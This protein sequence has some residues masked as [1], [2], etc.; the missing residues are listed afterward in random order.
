MSS[1]GYTWKI[2]A[3]PTRTLSLQALH[4]AAAVSAGQQGSNIILH[5]PVPAVESKIIMIDKDYSY[6]VI[7]IHIYIYGKT[8]GKLLPRKLGHIP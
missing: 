5:D 6:S 7:A 4:V 1:L 8:M 2:W 3:T